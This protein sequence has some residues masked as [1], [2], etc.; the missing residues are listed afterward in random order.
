MSKAKQILCIDP[1]PSDL[2]IGALLNRRGTAVDLT[3]VSTPEGLRN[4]LDRAGWWDLI[5]CDGESVEGLGVDTAI[6]PFRDDLDASLVLVKAAE[7]PLSVQQS[8]RLGAADLV[9]RDEIEHLLMVCERE[10]RSC[11]IRKELRVLRRTAG[12]LDPDVPRP[13]MLATIHDLS[14]AARPGTEDVPAAVAAPGESPV[15]DQARI[16]ALIDAGGLTLEFQPIISLSTHEEHRSMFE[17]LVRL[18][19]GTGK[20]LM[21]SEFLPVLESAG[22]MTKIDLWILR[23]AL[24]T[25]QEMQEGGAQDAVLFINVATETLS[26][27]ETVKALGAFISAA[28][29]ARGSVVIE[30]RKSAFTDA[31]AALERF[32]RSLQ[33][34]SHGLLIEDAGLDDCAFLAEHSDLITHVKLARTM[35][36]GLVE[37]RVPQAAVKALVQCA[38]KEGMR[39]IALAVDN[40]ELLPMLT[41]AGVDAIQGHFV[42]MPYQNLMYPSIQRVESSS[43]PAWQ[44]PERSD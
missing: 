26:S 40:A 16:R 24:A 30:V 22:W 13:V 15:S 19:D 21:P 18:K 11:A 23:R 5:L 6:L 12:I 14:R 9:V 20:L 29:L 36:Q 1:E 3:E 8:Y 27:A 4:A 28:R 10:L 43:G 37:R 34:K 7:S 38:Q 44:G 39:V 35:T 33:T 31:R 32:A 42:S 25:L 2:R 17:T 41:A